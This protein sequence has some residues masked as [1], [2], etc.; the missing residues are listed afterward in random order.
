[1]A[2]YYFRNVGTA[3]GTATN[4]SLTSGGGATGV[5]PTSADTAI[6]DVNST[7]CTVNVLG[8]CS[9]I[10]FTNYT[11][12]ITMT[13]GIS[14]W[15]NIT[16]FSG[17]TIGGSGGLTINAN[18]T[19]SP[20][21]KVW[22]NNITVSGTTSTITINTSLLIISGILTL[23]VSTTFAGAFGFTTTNFTCNTAGLTHTFLTGLTYTVTSNMTT[24][25]TNVSRIILRS[26]SISASATFTLNGTQDNA[27]LDGTWIN[28]SGGQTIWTYGGTL[29]NTTNWKDF[30]IFPVNTSFTFLGT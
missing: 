29:S 14:V 1:M 21:S 16:L 19:I 8:V 26:S 23:T 6:F 22:P 20:N 13:N 11:N 28:S 25:G 12:T 10:N 2:T 7:A 3:W 17:M 15:G 5:V 27:F 30:S 24:S 9:S 4:W 18:S